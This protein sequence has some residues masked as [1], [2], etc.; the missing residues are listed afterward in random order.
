MTFVA[1]P[2]HGIVDVAKDQPCPECGVAAYDL[3]DRGARDVVR[4]NRAAALKTRVAACAVGVF[5]GAF[6]VGL[7]LPLTLVVFGV[8]LV[9][10]FCGAL[11]ASFGA[12][13]LALKLEHNPRLRRLDSELAQRL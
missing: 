2:R 9:P 5:V 6:V 10:A 8:P 4:Q 7:T 13:P 3:A 12:R 1:C 11:A